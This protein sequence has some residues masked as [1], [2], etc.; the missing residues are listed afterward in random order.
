MHTPL[1]FSI[2]CVSALQKDV[3]HKCCFFFTDVVTTISTPGEIYQN[4]CK[5]IKNKLLLIDNKS[6][7]SH[8]QI[9]FTKSTPVNYQKTEVLSL[10]SGLSYKRALISSY[11]IYYS[12]T[13]AHIQTLKSKSFFIHQ[14]SPH[15]SIAIGSNSHQNMSYQKKKTESVFTVNKTCLSLATR[16]HHR[17]CCFFAK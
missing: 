16:C 10:G 2:Y 14:T 1:F 17:S 5:H 9:Y 6:N 11:S 13:V 3:I 8:F 15:Y 7:F 12:C 4:H